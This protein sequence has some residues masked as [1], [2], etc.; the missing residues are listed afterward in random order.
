[1]SDLKSRL[2]HTSRQIA[3]VDE[4]TVDTLSRLATWLAP[5]V[6]ALM[7][8]HAS[9]EHIPNVGPGQAAII[10][11]TIELLGLATVSNWLSVIEYNRH[12][13]T[14]EQIKTVGYLAMVGAYII[15]IGSIV[16][17]LKVAPASFSWVAIVM[18]SLLSFLSAVAF[19]QRRQH[20]SRM[21][22]IALEV[23]LAERDK[24]LERQLRRDMKIAEHRR[25]LADIERQAQ[26]GAD[27][28]HDARHPDSER[29]DDAFFDRMSEG[30][31]RK[32]EHRRQ[33]LLGILRQ[34]GDVGATLFA[35]RLNTSRTTI[36]SDLDALRDAGLVHK[37]GNGWEVNA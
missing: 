30:K 36:Y 24:E 4:F 35:K 9:Q 21:E 32:T 16:V 1:M 8:Y 7:V 34:D 18:M 37:N 13:S 28:Q 10:A 23:E 27:V 6:P 17:G 22:E 31:T 12:V 19:V 5:L 29:Q 25:R 11:A 2:K 20:A 14:K 33:E 26:A 3:T 15:A